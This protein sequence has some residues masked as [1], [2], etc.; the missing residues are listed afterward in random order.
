MLFVSILYATSNAYF[1][2]SKPYIYYSNQFSA[3][4]VI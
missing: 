3:Y 1:Y 2:A 4:N